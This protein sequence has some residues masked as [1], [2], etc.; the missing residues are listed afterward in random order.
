[1]TRKE[2]YQKYNDAMQAM[3][4]A[5]GEKEDHEVRLNQIIAMYRERAGIPYEC[6]GKSDYPGIPADFDWDEFGKD[7]AEL[8]KP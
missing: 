4:D 6:A 2:M 3:N 8:I 5:T 7:Y 1:M